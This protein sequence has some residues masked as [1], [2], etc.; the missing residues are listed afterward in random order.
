MKWVSLSARTVP[1]L[2]FSEPPDGHGYCHG[3]AADADKASVSKKVPTAVY[4]MPVLQ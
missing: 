1:Q 4:F 2:L 3:A